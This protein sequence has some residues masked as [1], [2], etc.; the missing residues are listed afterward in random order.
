MSYSLIYVYIL[1]K[2]YSGNCFFK[3]KALLESKLQKTKS[4]KFYIKHSFENLLLIV[5]PS[6]SLNRINISPSISSFWSY[7]GKAS[8]IDI[9]I[10]SIISGSSSYKYLSY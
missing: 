10:A 8:F 3:I 1:S 2:F 7:S 9:L 4:Y 6:G 5:F